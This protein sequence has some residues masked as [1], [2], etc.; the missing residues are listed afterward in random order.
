M[1]ITHDKDVIPAGDEFLLV[2]ISQRVIEMKTTNI[3]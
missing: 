2:I 1:N 3:D